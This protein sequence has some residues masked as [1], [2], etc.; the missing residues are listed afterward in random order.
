MLL[1][2][3]W[4]VRKSGKRTECK[5][6]VREVKLQRCDTESITPAGDA[7]EEMGGGRCGEGRREEE[8][9][10]PNR[11]NHIRMNHTRVRTGATKHHEK[12]RSE[13]S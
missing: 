10:M 5:G 13:P 7:G 1:R 4:V 12:A 2:M 9:D 6:R 8:V 11:Q 3:G